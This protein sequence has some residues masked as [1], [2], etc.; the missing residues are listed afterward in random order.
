MQPT[1]L[2]W[3]G[4]LGLIEQ[5][6]VFVYLDDAQYERGSWQ[7]RNRVLVGGRPRWLTVPVRREHLGQPITAVHTDESQP[8]R[9]KH[10]SLL[11]QAYARHPHREAMLELVAGLDGPGPI[12]LAELNIGLI[13]ACCARLGLSTRRLRAS[14]LGIGGVRSERLIA[15]CQALGATEYVSPPGARDYLEADGFERR[16]PA[17]LR[18]HAFEQPPYPQS[19]GGEFISHLSIVDVLASLG[20]EG[21]R[22]YLH[23][24]IHRLTVEEEDTP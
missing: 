20:W 17:R 9:R 11:R 16:A 22:D 8:W 18:Y 15:L 2:P 23:A 14:R 4:Y 24:G 21:T 6:D 10:L 3:A 1:Y 5:V 12:P 7:N 13:E 19:G